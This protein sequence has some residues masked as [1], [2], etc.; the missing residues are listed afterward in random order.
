MLF[1]S[2]HAPDQ[3]DHCWRL[4]IAPGRSL[5]ICA[6]CTGVYPIAFVLLVAQIAQILS[7]APTDPWLVLALPLP[8]VVEFLGEQLGAWRG[9][10]FARIATGLPLG[11]ALS[12][13]F[14]R[15]FAHPADPLF[16]GIV[17]VYGGVCG[18][19]AVGSLRKRFQG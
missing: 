9:T 14:V 1:L 17:A 12:R 2:H 8:A 13:L 7:L 4:P 6:R 11:V 18:V 5:P 10:N 19:A 15:Y 16:W 3:W